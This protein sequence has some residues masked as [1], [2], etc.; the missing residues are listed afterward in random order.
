MSL[1]YPANSR[2]LQRLYLE[3]GCKARIAVEFEESLPEAS[4][5]LRSI[6]QEIAGLTKTRKLMYLA[7]RKAATRG[8][9]TLGCS[10]P[11]VGRGTNREPL[12]P[13][14]FSG[15]ITHT[16]DFIVAVVCEQTTD[17]ELALGIDAEAYRGLKRE[18]YGTILTPF[19][20]E[21]LDRLPSDDQH[22]LALCLFSA[23]EALFKAQYPFTG[24]FVDFCEVTLELVKQAEIKQ[25]FGFLSLKQGPE[26][27]KPYEFG[28]F[29]YRLDSILL[30]GAVSRKR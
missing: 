25:E 8:L 19:E 11:F 16:G 28:L 7:G 3:A 2:Q 26:N 17:Y 5:S 14:G 23:K 27:L 22:D 13:A 1:D 20:L 12:W 4:L 24:A 6:P 15:S 9:K 18:D 29:F 21:K 30:T 10:E